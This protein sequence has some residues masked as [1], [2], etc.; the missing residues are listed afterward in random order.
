MDKRHL[1]RREFLKSLSATLGSLALMNTKLGKLF[2][3]AKGQ[4]KPVEAQIIKQ[5]DSQD[6]AFAPQPDFDD[7]DPNLLPFIENS[8]LKRLLVADVQTCITAFTCFYDAFY[9]DNHWDNAGSNIIED[10]MTRP[11]LQSKIGEETYQKFRALLKRARQR[12]IDEGLEEEYQAIE[13]QI[14]ASVASNNGEITPVTSVLLSEYLLNHHST[15]PP[16]CVPPGAVQPADMVLM[17]PDI[18]SHY[19]AQPNVTELLSRIAENNGLNTWHSTDSHGRDVTLS[20]ID[21]SSTASPQWPDR[22]LRTASVVVGLANEK[23]DDYQMYERTFMI[24]DKHRRKSKTD[25][26][27]E[28]TWYMILDTV[29]DTTLGDTTVHDDHTGFK[30]G[31]LRL[32]AV[33]QEELLEEIFAKYKTGFVFRRTAEEPIADPAAKTTAVAN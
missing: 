22:L 5:P 2:L 31:T 24:L 11:D 19:G 32:R 15:V 28:E 6:F 30:V 14:S 23:E 33:R 3:G 12:Y 16:E 26:L 29:P 9:G 21:K 25:D 10:I 18:V 4:F 13:L 7:L 17:H 27:V 20:R 1:S 8:E